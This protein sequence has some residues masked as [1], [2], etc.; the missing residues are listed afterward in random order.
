MKD[1]FEFI[2]D[3]EPL[4]KDIKYQKIL[5]RMALQTIECG[6]FIQDYLKRGF[7]KL[8]YFMLAQ[9]DKVVSSQANRGIH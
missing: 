4:N 9:V 3:G 1:T 6:Y 8:I 2:K 7:C 5:E